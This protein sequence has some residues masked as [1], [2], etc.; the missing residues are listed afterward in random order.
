MSLN[1]GN[2][3]T[4]FFLELCDL[5][6]TR[7][8]SARL[9]QSISLSTLTVASAKLLCVLDTLRESKK[10]KG[11]E[12]KREKKLGDTNLYPAEP[13]LCSQG[14]RGDSL[15]RPLWYVFLPGAH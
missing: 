3:C 7:H 5:V 12:R 9:E 4:V 15:E 8:G 2:S 1:N 10:E 11:R 14:Y 6:V 13:L